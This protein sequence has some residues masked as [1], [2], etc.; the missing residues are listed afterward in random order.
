[1]SLSR[2]LTE[3]EK[4]SINDVFMRLLQDYAKSKMEGETGLYPLNADDF[5][6]GLFIGMSVCDDVQHLPV[7]IVDLMNSIGFTQSDTEQQPEPN[8]QVS[9]RLQ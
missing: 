5:T 4:D 6:A 7:T 2:K 1:M 3:E 9:E 8:A